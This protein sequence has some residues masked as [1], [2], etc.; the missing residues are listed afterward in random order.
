MDNKVWWQSKAVWGSLLGLVAMAL[1][2]FHID[3]D[4]GLQADIVNGLMGLIGAGLAIYGR[5]TANA[6]LKASLLN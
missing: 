1:S 2:F 3:L 6:P 4:I 5:F